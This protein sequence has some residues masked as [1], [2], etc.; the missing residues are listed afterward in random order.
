MLGCG[1]R[2]KKN[3]DLRHRHLDVTR[4][5]VPNG[6]G[7]LVDRDL[8]IGHSQHAPNVASVQ[9]LRARSARGVAVKIC[10]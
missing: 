10:S 7:S 6:S 5:I 3:G 8:F 4:V 9:M 2:R 1:P